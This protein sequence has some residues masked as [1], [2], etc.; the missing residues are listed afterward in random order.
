MVVDKEEKINIYNIRNPFYFKGNR[1]EVILKDGCKAFLHPLTYCDLKQ[2]IPFFESLSNE[3]LFYRYL[4][5]SRNCVERELNRLQKALD[6]NEI[7]L[8]AEVRA[9]KQKQIIAL[10]ELAAQR[11]DSTLAECAITVTD[12][13]QGKTLGPQMLEWTVSLA[14]ERGIECI[15]GWYTVENRK[16]SALLQKSGYYYETN[17]SVDVISFKLFLNKCLRERSGKAND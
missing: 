11:N 14:Q 17:R 1:K 10:S 8:I 6:D 2:L 7:I 4:S 12:L 5:A 9:F 3:T 16:V 13:W 15:I